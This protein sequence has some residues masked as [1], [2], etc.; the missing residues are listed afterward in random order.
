MHHILAGFLQA[1]S[2]GVRTGDTADGKPAVGPA[3]RAPT[4]KRGRRVNEGVNERL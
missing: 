4:V 3:L 1:P 2:S